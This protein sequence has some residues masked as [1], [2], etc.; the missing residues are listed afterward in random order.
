MRTPVGS[1]LALQ[2]A[3]SPHDEDPTLSHSSLPVANILNSL[4]KDEFGIS[5][6]KEECFETGML[7]IQE[8]LNQIS[9][10]QSPKS[11]VSSIPHQTPIT[12]SPTRTS[13][14]QSLTSSL[15]EQSKGFE[16]GYRDGGQQHSSGWF[17]GL[18][19]CLRPVWSI[20][21]KGSSNEIK[22]QD[23]WEIP[24]ESIRDLQWLGSG[25]QGAVFLGTL[26]NELVAVKKVRDKSETDIK[27][28]RK[29]RHPHIVASKGVCTQ[30]PCYCIVM[31]YCPYGP[32]YEV[33]RQGR[34]VP[35]AVVVEWSK[36]IA[37][38]MN[39]LH[40][41][42]IIH[43]DLKSPNVLIS[44]NEILKISDFGTSRQWNEISTKMSFAGTVAWMAPEIIRNEPCSEKVD[45]WSFG[46]VVWELLT[47]EVPYKDVDSSAVIWGVGSNSLHLPLPSTC[48]NGFKLLMKQCWSAKPRNRPSFRHILMHLDISAV[49]I[50]STPKEAYFKTQAA[51]KA[52][53]KLCMEKIK[54]NGRHVSH[55]EEDLVNRRREE[56][57]HAQDVREH[58]ERKL[59]KANNLYMELTACMLQIE[60]REKDL[61]KREQSMQMNTSGNKPYRKRIV[62]PLLKA[63][64]RF[65]KKRTYK[66]QCEQISSES[67]KKVGLTITD[68]SSLHGSAKAR[69]RRQ[70]H[71][72]SNSQSGS[73]SYNH[74]IS[75]NKVPSPRWSSSCERRSY[76]DTETQTESVDMQSETDPISPCGTLNS[77]QHS[78]SVQ[79]YNKETS[80]NSE[81]DILWR[82]SLDGS[83]PDVAASCQ[84]CNCQLEQ[85]ERDSNMNRQQKV[86]TSNDRV[87]IKMNR[88]RSEKLTYHNFQLKTLKRGISTDSDESPT[89]LTFPNRRNNINTTSNMDPH[90]TTSEEEGEVD[91]S[92]DYVLRNSIRL[93]HV[94]QR[95]SGQSI[96]TLSSEG[97]LS[98]E[99]EGNTSEYGSSHHTPNDLLS[100]LSN[101]DLSHNLESQADVSKMG[102]NDQANC[103]S[104]NEL[105]ENLETDKSRKNAPSLHQDIQNFSPTLSAISSSGDSDDISS[106]TVATTHSRINGSSETAVW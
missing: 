38:G 66:S 96:S 24:F 19:G 12:S 69:I 35:P 13:S 72:R 89:R 102:I 68:C 105:R 57:R 39:Y 70:R 92:D 44:S 40:S 6:D 90:Y 5:T 32:L 22:G 78:E 29:L 84:K 43:R 73:G 86:M 23:D 28:L 94:H 26:N 64:E 27:H 59:E 75:S 52:E 99:E 62:R 87:T 60:E 16:V 85:T 65:H 58:Y 67:P 17:D 41:H 10:K 3:G 2:K 104:S 63:H 91:D 101:P 97:I 18:L 106:K 14:I 80:S 9:L 76:V 4:D 74:L 54:Y 82:R 53:V 83:L 1:T 103:H 42:K 36:Q 45:I 34:E 30:A 98:E 21:G 25:A 15:P 31:E 81:H 37:S 48:P 71:R 79:N 11:P 7:C 56:L 47:C 88:N 100:S 46:V 77:R 61:I 33:L 50:L 93:S 20:L 8:E 49:E 51:W 55:A 95:C